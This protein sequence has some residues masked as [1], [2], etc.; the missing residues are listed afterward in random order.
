M[1]CY[2]VRPPACIWWDQRS[3]LS[4]GAG[5]SAASNVV[6]TCPCYWLPQGMEGVSA[7]AVAGMEAVPLPV[8]WQVQQWEEAGSSV[9]VCY[10][11]RQGVCLSWGG[12]EAPV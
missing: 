3:E 11:A 2:A 1:L 12:C 10:K 5:G 8:H 4:L 7:G 6:D 9:E